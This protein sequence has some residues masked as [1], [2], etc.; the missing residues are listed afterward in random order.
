[1]LI[2]R[3]KQAENALADGRLDEAYELIRADDLRSH[4]QGQRLVGSLVRALA[5]RG[6][7]HLSAERLAEAQADCQK[8]QRLG[9]NLPEV[10]DLKV[11]VT[12]A[13]AADEKSVRRREF[14]VAKAKEHLA[15]GRLSVGEEL[16]AEAGEDAE[17]K[18]LAQ[19]LTERRLAIGS[20]V[21]RVESALERDDW[22]VAI[23]EL[24][25]VK[26][27]I[28]ADDRLAELTVR[29]LR[30]VIRQ[31]RSAIDDGRVDLADGLLGRLGPLA[32]DALEVR[33]LTRIV[34]QCR[35]AGKY[36][37]C[38]Q[39]RQAGQILRRLDSIL[40]AAEWLDQAIENADRAADGLDGLR[41]GPLGLI[42]PSGS[43]ITDEGAEDDPVALEPAEKQADNVP[44][45]TALPAKFLLQ[46][47]GVG[48]FLVLR[49]K[50]V[51]IGPV[52]SSQLPDVGLM[53]D[54]NLPVATIERVDEDYF[55]R[56]EVPIGINDKATTSKL[57]ANGDRIALAPRCR[58]KFFVPNAASTS[59]V[60]VLSGAKLPRADVRQAILLDRE[61]ILGPGPLAHIRADQ[62][63]DAVTLFVQDGRLRCR[64]RSPVTADKRALDTSDGIPMDVPVRIGSVSLVLTKV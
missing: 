34:G 12:A 21:K 13:T 59:A 24:V 14:I 64:A 55:I 43:Q 3:I 19:E 36:I 49:N 26:R 33:E 5:E 61:M 30:H 8:A 54:P 58:L 38:G 17:A 60:L 62:L 1:M 6:N 18:V 11:A 42:M 25:K 56:A 31:V 35:R 23:D 20:A 15:D 53:A 32:D 4:R 45:D 50:T 16:L 37:Q 27:L 9:G 22:T 10:A 28:S 51:T 2:L 29:L 44:A 47:D 40:P 46:V 52:S 48:S 7:A 41:T 39:I 63:S 57:L